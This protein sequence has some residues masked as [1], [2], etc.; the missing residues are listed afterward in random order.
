MR[1][2]LNLSQIRGMTSNEQTIN[3]ELAREL[4][5]FIAC[6]RIGDIEVLLQGD[7]RVEG[8]PF[9]RDKALDIAG[10]D[11]SFCSHSLSFW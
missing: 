4:P 10:P 6:G 11:V 1:G 8:S 3:K 2:T 5:G 7:K 9:E